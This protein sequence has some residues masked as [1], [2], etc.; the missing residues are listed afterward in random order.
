MGVP[1]QDVGRV[2]VDTGDYFQSA[3]VWLRRQLWASEWSTNN[4]DVN[5]T[6]RSARTF[7]LDAIGGQSLPTRAGG[8]LMAT[9]VDVGQVALV[10]SGDGPGRI[11][12]GAGAITTVGNGPG[13]A[14]FG[15]ACLVA[16]GN[17]P[18][19]G[20]IAQSAIAIVGDG[21]GTADIAQGFVTVVG[22]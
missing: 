13:I 8:G 18:G 19:I 11:S 2:T 5:W 16:V 20:D 15:Q 7:R 14:D 3:G 4:C 22:A 17:G 12:V 6:D 9:A 1:L 10:I 21:S